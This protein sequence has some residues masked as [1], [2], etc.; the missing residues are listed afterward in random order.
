[1]KIEVCYNCLVKIESV[2][3]NMYHISDFKKL[4]RCPKQ[5][6]LSKRVEKEFVPYITYNEDIIALSIELLMIQNVFTGQPN[7]PKELAIE[8]FKNKKNLVNARFSY[9]DL[10]VK[11]P[12]LLQEE[13]RV[14]VYFPFV[15]CY[16]KESEAQMMADTL[17]VLEKCDIKVDEVYAIH[18]NADYIREETLDVRK[19]LV[20]NDHLFNS[21]NHPHGC[22]K[23]LIA[24]YTR[25]LLPLLEALRK[26]DVQEKIETKRTAVC[27]RGGKCAYYEQ[28]FPETLPSNSIMHLVQSSHKLEMFEEGR[29]RLQDADV[30]RIEGTRFQFAQIMADRNNGLFIDKGAIRIW[31][32]E[33]IHYPIS[34]LDFEWETLAYPPYKGMKPFDVLTFQYSLHI[35][36]ENG[37][38]EQRGF[39]GEKD[40]REDFIRHLINDLPK[41]GS[42]LV[43]NMEGAEKL[44]LIQL[45]KQFSQYKDELQQIWERMVDLSLPFSS[46]NIYDLRMEGMYSLKKLVPIFSDYTYE[47][48]SVSHG[49]EA[50]Q[51]WR[52]YETS[53][54]E[55]K[56][57]LYQALYEYCAMDT[58]AEYII[59]HALKDLVK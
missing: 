30:D 11:V 41:E 43:Y 47:S 56:E 8:A 36:K 59:Y 1:M 25:D 45:A 2:E 27:T 13:E 34:Y 21:K 35:E 28:C 3:K 4:E 18:L 33:H 42:I 15:N 54:K 50:V 49:M 58:Y 57:E 5:Y 9:E 32:K 44:R 48:L 31:M 16:P 19:L 37:D 22:I 39:I 46:G 29:T 23:D 26:L 14:Q 10:R 38:L 24:E 20:V 40:C 12:I 55:R 52:E 17:S 53:Q 51:C 7:D 6:W